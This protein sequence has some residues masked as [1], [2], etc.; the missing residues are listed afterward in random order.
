VAAVKGERKPYASPLRD[1]QAAQTRRAVLAAAQ[2]LFLS[3]G[4]AATTVE[5]IA[6]AAGVSKPT[7]FSAVGNKQT[8]L[9]A[10]RDAIASGRDGPVSKKEPSLAAL[11]RAE[12]DP[13]RAVEL[14]ATRVSELGR[15]NAL[16][17]E[18]VRGAATGGEE[19]PRELWTAAENQRLRVARAI[20]A[21]L[22][23]KGWL[24]DGLEVK[25]TADELWLL[26]APDLYYRLVHL[27]HWSARRFEAWL[28]DRLARLLPPD[29]S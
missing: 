24:R 17:D 10:V 6:D 20:A 19:G 28:A 21:T 29:P 1:E 27:R 12:Q 16:I 9:A 26:M 7:V 18:V 15:R 22:G 11:I 5:Q 8:V 14:L 3:Q 4:Y 25:A 2:D 23:D 13:R